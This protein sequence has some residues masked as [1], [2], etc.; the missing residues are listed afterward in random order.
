MSR[1]FGSQALSRFFPASEKSW[2]GPGDEATHVYAGEYM[3]CIYTQLRIP[4]E[5][6]SLYAKCRELQKRKTDHCAECGVH[7]NLACCLECG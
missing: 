3:L 4:G 1:D 2:E 6:K 5:L 7:S